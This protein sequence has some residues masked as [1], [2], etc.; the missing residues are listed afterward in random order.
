MQKRGQDNK[1]G[2][3]IRIHFMR[4]WIQGFIYMRIRILGLKYLRIQIR[5][6]AFQKFTAFA[7]HR[8]VLISSKLPRVTRGSEKARKNGSLL[9]K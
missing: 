8:K 1:A 6:R 3:R 5:L 9:N 2:F 4:I 7:L